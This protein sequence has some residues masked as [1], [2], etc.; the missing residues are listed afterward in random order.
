MAN[1]NLVKHLLGLFAEVVTITTPS[2]GF[3]NG[4]RDGER[5]KDLRREREN[6]GEADARHLA[7]AVARALF[8]AEGMKGGS[9]G[10]EKSK[11]VH[12][13]LAL[14]FLIK[15]RGDYAVSLGADGGGRGG[16]RGGEMREGQ[17]KAEFLPSTREILEWKGQG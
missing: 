4:D 17:K 16:T 15:K 8:H 6:I 10:R 13:T 9:G 3:W 5:E 1:R 11:H 7:S 12:A 2:P 14:A